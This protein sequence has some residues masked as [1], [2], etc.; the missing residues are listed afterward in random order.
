MS[1]PEINWQDIEKNLDDLCAVEGGFSQA[2]R[3]LITL[4]D[5][6][7]IFVKVGTND[8]TRRWTSKEIASYRFLQKHNYPHIPQLL[9]TNDDHS[10]LAITAHTPEHGWD[11]KSNWTHER[12]NK[13][14][15]AMDALAAIKPVDD[16]LIC[17]SDTSLDENNDGWGPLSQSSEL[18]RILIEK[19]HAASRDDIASSINFTDEA[20]KS[21]QYIFKN[22]A[23]VHNDIRADNCAWNSVT[24]EV[25]L[26]DWNWVQ[27]GDRRT[28]LASMLVDVYRSGLD[29]L[30]QHADK[31]DA[32]ALHWIAGFWLKAA[33]SPIW[34][35]GPDNLRHFQLMAGIAALDLSNRL[36]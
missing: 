16:D 29:I 1:K 2:K 15:E 5:G 26:V 25:R 31:L 12:L 30:P 36:L 3:G 7:R 34:P 6:T 19:L 14:L 13:T 32:D 18:Q 10:G 4:A 27:M 35:G 22:D 21:R 28:D 17:F 9:A 33:T 24:N 20:E 8:N 23:L 11:W